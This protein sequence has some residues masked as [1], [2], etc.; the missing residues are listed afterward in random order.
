MYVRVKVQRNCKY[1]SANSSSLRPIA[2]LKN[3]NGGHVIICVDDHCYVL[4]VKTSIGFQQSTHWFHEAITLLHLLP[5][6]PDLV[7]YE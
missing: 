2:A 5:E 3:P 4:Y 7:T 6:N 1:I